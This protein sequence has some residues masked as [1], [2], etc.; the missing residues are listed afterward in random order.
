M[1]HLKTPGQEPSR[2]VQSLEAPG[3]PWLTAASLSTWSPV[4]VSVASYGILCLSMQET[5]ETWV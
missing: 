3:V 2:L 4:C 5:K 1:L